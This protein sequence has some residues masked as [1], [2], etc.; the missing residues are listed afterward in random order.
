[1]IYR[2]DIQKLKKLN[3][4]LCNVNKKLASRF[5]NM[6]NSKKSTASLLSVGSYSSIK[7]PVYLWCE[8]FLND[9]KKKNYL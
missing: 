7:V 1:M 2:H 9:F 3:N 5:K 4:M 8:R 6:E